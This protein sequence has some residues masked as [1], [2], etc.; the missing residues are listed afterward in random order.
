MRKE[1]LGFCS[2]CRSLYRVP[3]AGAFRDCGVLCSLGLLAA[4]KRPDL[5][6]LLLLG[7][8]LFGE[9]VE[10]WVMARCPACGIA[11]RLVA[12]QI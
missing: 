7:S 2:S 6:V 9:A 3:T 11:L 10:H 4:R 8:L 5:G 1:D 12:A